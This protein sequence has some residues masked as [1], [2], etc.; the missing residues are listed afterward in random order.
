MFDEAG[1]D[2]GR[3]ILVAHVVAAERG[4]RQRG[5]FGRADQRHFAAFRKIL[6]Q[7]WV[8]SRFTVPLVPST[9]TRLVFEVAQAGLIAGTV[10]TNGTL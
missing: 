2:F 6:D 8:Y 4:F 7:A 1:G 5:E 3:D 9:E 10:P